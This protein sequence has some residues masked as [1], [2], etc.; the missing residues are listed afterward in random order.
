[1]LA[2]FKRDLKSFYVT[3]I[4]CAFTAFIVGIVG[5]YFSYYCLNSGYPYFGDV[6]CNVANIMLL[7]LPIITMKSFAEEQKTKTDQILYTSRLS[8]TKIVLGK[9]LAMTTVWLLPILLCCICPIIVNHLGRAHY[10]SDYSSILAVFLLGCAYIAIGMFISSL[11]ESSIIAGVSTF[12]ILLI[13]QLMNG[14]TSFYSKTAFASLIGLLVLIVAFSGIY[15]LLTKNKYIAYLIAILGSIVLILLYF[16]NE[17][18][19]NNLLPDF[20]NKIPL[21]SS[22]YNFSMKIFDVTALIYYISVI[23]VFIFLTTQSIKKRRYS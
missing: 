10:S 12:A 1:M 17:S 5:I 8:I 13:F 19:F 22:L 20:L 18:S 4:G 6:L 9:F 15:Y 3:M 16:N 11:T 2:V 14:I 23:A 21:T 7:A